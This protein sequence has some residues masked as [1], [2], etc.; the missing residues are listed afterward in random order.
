M[1]E[2][3][4]RG[5]ESVRGAMEPRRGIGGARS[6]R[7]GWGGSEEGF[8]VSREGFRVEGGGGAPSAA[9]LHNLLFVSMARKS[10]RAGGWTK[11]GLLVA[12]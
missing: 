9:H 11:T 6:T 10:G 12:R 3:G 4:R 8:R 1:G 2:T 5:R 7:P